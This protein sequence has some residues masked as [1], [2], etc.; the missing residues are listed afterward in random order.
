MRFGRIGN[1]LKSPGIALALVLHALFFL[2]LFQL[3][4][5][6]EEWARVEAR[7]TD[8]STGAYA[9]AILQ[10]LGPMGL[11]TWFFSTHGETKLYYRYARLTLYGDVDYWINEETQ[12]I[13][14]SRPWPY[15]DVTIEYPPGALLAITLPAL[16]SSDYDGY[17]FWLGTWFGLLYMLNL[18]LGLQ[19]AAGG[20][21][22]PSQVNR[23]LWGSVMFL[24]CFG[25]I[26]VSR[27][28]HVVPAF[29]LLAAWAFARALGKEGKLAL[30]GFGAFGLAAALGV[31]TKIVPGLV[32]PAAIL[33]LCLRGRNSNRLQSIAAS[34]GGLATGLVL[35]NALF[36]WLFGPGYFKTF[37][38]H[39]QRGIQIESVYS[40]ILLLV[41]LTGGG[42]LVD[43]SFGSTNIVSSFL[44]WELKRLSPW[45]FLGT[46]LWISRQVWK[47]RNASREPEDQNVPPAYSL[48]LITLIF[49]LAIIL[50][51]KVF[52]P[53]Y[54][55]WLGP[56]MAV[57]AAVRKDM[58]KIGVIFLL[59]TALT[60]VLFPHLYDFLENFHPAMVAVLNLRNVLLV[61]VLI[62][63]VRDLP[64][65]LRKNQEDESSSE[66]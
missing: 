54:L 60:Q 16:I 5:T 22:S 62:L 57:L 21:P 24:L 9:R 7:A 41:H 18:F 53:Q 40:G 31:L 58:V 66:S 48:I 25:G 17:R 46:A 27:F 14:A 3:Q 1:G 64:V 39:M 8:K 61:L 36:F 55:I 20:N 56:L 10:E 44:T 2:W 26:V 43:H 12:L 33:V 19:L 38:Y 49:L 13:V 65:L 28:D 15:R 47:C 45:M 6:G 52:S 4:Y 50:T 30:I 37:T 63:L 11:V 42:L 32:I 34:L 51:S 59:A 35:L 23:M 29:V